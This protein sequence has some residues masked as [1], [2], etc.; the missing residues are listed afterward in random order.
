MT[1]LQTQTQTL[2]KLTDKEY[3]EMV[4]AFNLCSSAKDKEQAIVRWLRKYNVDNFGKPVAFS[5][6]I[7]LATLPEVTFKNDLKIQFYTV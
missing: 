6:P 5:S 7:G 1:N 2:G 4:S 3:R